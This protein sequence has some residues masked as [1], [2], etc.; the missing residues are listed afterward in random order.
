MRILITRPRE[1]AAALAEKLK[2]RGHDVIVEP[3]LEIRPV[4]GAKVDLQGV[5]AVVFSSANGVR[6]FA[7]AESRRDLPALCVGD[8]TAAAAR[9]AGFSGHMVK[10]V[11]YSALLGL[12]ASL[13]ATR[14]PAAAPRSG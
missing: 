7:L 2:A 5:Q 12:L 1:D 4:A 9:E 3:M 11:D 14:P 8:T 10:P 13:D 6:A